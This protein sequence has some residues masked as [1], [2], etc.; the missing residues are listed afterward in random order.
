VSVGVLICLAASGVV[1]GF[2]ALKE[3]LITEG[4]YRDLCTTEELDR[5]DRLCYL[6][7]QRCV[8]YSLLNW[9]LRFRLTIYRLNLNFIIGSVTTNLSALLVG[10]S[11]DRYGPRACGLISS[12]VL[13]LGSLSMA[14]AA[15]LPF[16]GYAVGFFLLALGG[17]FSFVPSFHLSN[18]FPRLQG[19]ILALITG[20]FDA[21]AAVFLAFRLLYQSTNGS[22]SVRQFFLLYL[23]VPVLVLLANLFLLPSR[24]YETRAELETHRT[25]LENNLADLHDSDDDLPATDMV[26]IRSGRAAKRAEAAAQITDLIGSQVQQIDHEIKEDEKKIA[27]GVWGILH[28]VSARK[29]M[30][31]PWFIL[32]ALFTVLQMTRFNFFIATIWSQYEYMLDSAKRATEVTEFFDLALPIG[33]VATVPFIGLLLDNT[34]TVTVLSLLVLM[35]TVIGALG[36]MPNETAAYANVC[37]FVIFRPLYYSAMSDYTAKIFGFSTFGTV[38]GTIICLSGFSLF[39]QPLLQ[40]LVHESFYE[41]PGPVNLGLAGAGLLIGIALVLFVDAQARDIRRMQFQVLAGNLDPHDLDDDRRSLLS[42]SLGGGTLSRAGHGGHAGG[43][44]SYGGG[45]GSSL[46]RMRSASPLLWP[47]DL[48]QSTPINQGLYANYGSFAFSGGGL[49]ASPGL[50]GITERLSTLNEDPATPSP[51]RLRHAN[52]RQ[53]LG[54]GMSQHLAIVR[55]RDEP[56]DE[57]MTERVPHDEEGNGEM[58][59]SQSEDMGMSGISSRSENDN[60]Y[61]QNDE[62]SDNEDAA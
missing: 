15:S 42:V 6:Q 44:P 56:E 31:S 13:L 49:T 46:A 43:V 50:P 52:S 51:Y 36:A 59:A 21:S 5:E 3:V 23:F 40:A 19:L 53:G 16:D 27:S 4:A 24:S 35:S 9:A 28:G 60:G 10:S 39:S 37:L 7:D 8:C 12:V 57:P 1:F 2:A 55:E 47:A 38:Y 54:Q 14:F 48:T 41:D 22:F 33:G 20:A 45:P 26:R 62:G 18:A 32:I 30:T 25:T 17:T 58:S 61:N 34:S 11:L 29:Q